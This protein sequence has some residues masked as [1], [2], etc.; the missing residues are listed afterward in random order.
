M[1]Q[2]RQKVEK[3]RSL[4]LWNWHPVLLGVCHP[5]QEE[6][7][8]PVTH[9]HLPTYRSAVCTHSAPLATGPL[10]TQPLS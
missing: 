9:A 3:I 1:A 2:F 10:L 6:G 7:N 4:P 5:K 8:T